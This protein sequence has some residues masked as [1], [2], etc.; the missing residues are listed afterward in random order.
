MLGENELEL[1]CM[2]AELE[3][4]HITTNEPIEPKLQEVINLLIEADV[5]LKSII[6]KFQRGM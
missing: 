4:E 2:I 1:V 5:K 6:Q 3:H